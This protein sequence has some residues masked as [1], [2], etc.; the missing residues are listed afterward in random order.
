[1]EHLKESLALIDDVMDRLVDTD[2]WN[3][4]LMSD[5][6]I[7]QADAQ[8]TAKVDALQGA[9]EWK[10]LDELKNSA[11]HLNN[12]LVSAAILY[13]M[14]VSQ[15]IREVTASPDTITE[16]SQFVLNRMAKKRRA[17]HEST[18]GQNHPF[19]PGNPRT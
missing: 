6:M 9:A 3:K 2:M 18:T 16:L 5:P 12:T 19:H 1:M 11:Q 14:R 17:R 4:I 10:Q 13:G 7:M 8:F 15:A